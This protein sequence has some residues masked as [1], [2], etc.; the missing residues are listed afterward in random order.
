MI[1]TEISE[2]QICRALKVIVGVLAKILQRN[3]TNILCACVCVCVC[4]RE[5]DLWSSSCGA[6]GFVMSLQ[7]VKGPSCHSCGTVCNSSSDLIPGLGISVCQGRAN[8][9]E[10][11]REREKFILKNWLGGPVWLSGNEFE[12][13]P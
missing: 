4:V 3:R 11:K 10:K 12:L 2:D 8:K 9:E 6:T 13:Y 5:R 1:H 7:W